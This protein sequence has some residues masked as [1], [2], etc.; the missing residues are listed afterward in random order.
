MKRTREKEIRIKAISKLENKFHFNPISIKRKTISIDFFIKHVLPFLIVL[1]CHYRDGG[2]GHYLYTEVLLKDDYRYFKSNSF[3][4]RFR[5]TFWTRK[6]CKYNFFG[7]G[8]R[9]EDGKWDLVD[10]FE[11]ETYNFM[12]GYRHNRRNFRYIPTDKVI[13][14][15]KKGQQWIYENIDESQIERD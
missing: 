10:D 14:D 2:G 12:Y 13:R 7:I 8:Q 5:R 9:D 6:V 1:G 15:I 11:Y 3:W 4:N